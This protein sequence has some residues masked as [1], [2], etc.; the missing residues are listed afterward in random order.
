M[1]K[2]DGVRDGLQKLKFCRRDSVK[3]D[4][5]H[6][7]FR[8]AGHAKPGLLTFAKRKGFARLPTVNLVNFLTVA[9][10]LP[11]TLQPLPSN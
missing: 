11:S 8:G 1:P 7:Q 5:H 3:P 6:F 10:L 4:L 2:V 9:K